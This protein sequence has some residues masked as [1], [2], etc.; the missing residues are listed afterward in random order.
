MKIFLISLILVQTIFNSGTSLSEIACI[1]LRMRNPKTTQCNT[2]N[3][4]K[5][6][7]PDCGPDCKKK[8]NEFL[9]KGWEKQT[10]FNADKQGGQLSQ[11]IPNPAENETVIPYLIPADSFDDAYISIQ[12]VMKGMQVKRIDLTQAGYSVAT[13]NLEGLP[14]GVYTYTLVV[15]GIKQDV[16][17]MVVVK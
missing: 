10:G 3:T 4:Y 2:Q 6:S 12:S 13:V 11:N 15:N 17:R 1:Q 5:P 14:S 7:Y 8:K 16:K 9:K